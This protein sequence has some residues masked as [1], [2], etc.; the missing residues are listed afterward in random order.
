M[1]QQEGR[2]IIQGQ[3][4]IESPKSSSIRILVVDDSRLVR[5][6]MTD[7]LEKNGYRITTVADGYE[8]LS[9]FR[10]ETIDILLVDYRMPG[11]DG[12]QLMRAI[13]AISLKTPIVFLT[14]TMNLT[15]AIEMVPSTLFI[16][17]KT[18]SICFER[19]GELQRSFAMNAISF[20]KRKLAS[21]RRRLL[22][23]RALSW[24]T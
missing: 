4:M 16:R 10:P 15:T 14:G 9:V 18:N 7:L 24:R 8:A 1:W 23:P 13:H 11:M 22:R 3:Q 19:S 2:L 6:M 12:N 21:K 17:H 20:V 5:T